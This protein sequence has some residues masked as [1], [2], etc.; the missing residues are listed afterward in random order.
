ML[1]NRNPAISPTLAHHS[2]ARLHPFERLPAAYSIYLHASRF[3][4]DCANTL[5]LKLG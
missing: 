1:E 4:R 5:F 3:R 2:G